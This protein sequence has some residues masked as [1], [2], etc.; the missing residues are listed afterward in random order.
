[1]IHKLAQAQMCA[2]LGHSPPPPWVGEASRRGRGIVNSLEFFVLFSVSRQA[3]GW[4]H[5][6]IWMNEKWESLQ[7]EGGNGY[8]CHPPHVSPLTLGP[9][10]YKSHIYQVIFKLNHISKIERHHS[11]PS[12]LILS[13]V[14]SKFSAFRGDVQFVSQSMYQ[15][16]DVSESQRTI[17][18]FLSLLQTVSPTTSKL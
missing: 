15:S 12:N 9:N 11:K 6:N 10:P 13:G 7:E 16:S 8:I 18:L 14:S 17:S 1:M 5:R 3:Y 2:D 4:C